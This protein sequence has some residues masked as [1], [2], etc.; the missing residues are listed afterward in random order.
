MP[1][2]V[3][4]CGITSLD[5]ALSAVEAG[6]DALGFIFYP[7]SPRFIEPDQAAG[8]IS[9]LPPFVSTVGVFV[10]E[11][12]ERI[13]AVRRDA[14]LATVQLHGRE[15]AA[16][17]RK[18]SPP[19]I[20]AVRVKDAASLKGLSEYHVSALLLDSYVAGQPGGTGAKF[21]WDLALDAKA[22]GKPVILAGGLNPENIADAVCK[23]R[24]WGVDVSSGVESAPG[25]KNPVLVRQFILRAKEA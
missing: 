11:S 14:S 9:R 6:A 15:D 25:I 12:P 20:K 24:P 18:I 10:D 17:C 8:I 19:V 3:K 22:F 5:D 7:G 21:N 23:V 13:A 4:I 2:R 1:V 16:F